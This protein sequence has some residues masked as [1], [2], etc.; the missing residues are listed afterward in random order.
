MADGSST[1][2]K[3]EKRK[4]GK[5]KFSGRKLLIWL[6]FTGALAVICGIIGYLLIILNGE[7]ILSE[8][9]DKFILPEAST[10]YD[11]GGHEVV[12]LLQSG[13]NREVVE[14]DQIPK[15]VRDAVIATRG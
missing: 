8:N 11:S 3:V 4:K 5:R 7:R 1:K 12:K 13:S 15:L 14:F 9:Q 6:F 2:K 10:I